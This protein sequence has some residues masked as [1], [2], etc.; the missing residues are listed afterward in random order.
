MM[1]MNHAQMNGKAQTSDDLTVL[2]LDIQNAEIQTDK[3]LDSQQSTIKVK[4]RRY[5]GFVVLD[6]CSGPLKLDTTLPLFS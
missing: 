3:V 2:D 6:I 4:P 5:K 1:K